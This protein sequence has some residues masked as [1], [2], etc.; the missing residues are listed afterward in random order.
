[1]YAPAI[2]ETISSCAEALYRDAR[3]E[4][5]NIGNVELVLQY[6]DTEVGYYFIDHS[7]QCLFWVHPFKFPVNVKFQFTG[8]Q[9]SKQIGTFSAV[10]PV[11]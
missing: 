1:M 4:N 9:Q 8:T 5:E 3:L 6:W 7:S 11:Q 10:R 2:S